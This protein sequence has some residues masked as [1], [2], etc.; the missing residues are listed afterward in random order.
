MKPYVEILGKGDELPILISCPHAGTTIP[1]DIAV[2][3]HPQFH[4]TQPDS[5]WLIHRLYEFASE[6]GCHIIYGVYSRYVIDLNRNPEGTPHYSDGRRETKLCPTTTFLGD[7]IYID[8]EPDKAEIARRLELYYKPY[9]D[10]VRKIL[11]QKRRQNKHILLFEAHSIAR[12]VPLIRK[13]PFPDVMLG[14]NEGKSAHQDIV[15]LA[16]TALEKAGLNVTLNNPFKGGYLTCSFGNPPEGIHAM[17]LEMA[18]DLYL[19]KTLQLDKEKA[20][21]I[22]EALKTTLISIGKKLRELN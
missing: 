14:D 5:D 21:R 15:L 6:L 2:D 20:G 22:Q 8:K 9:H 18:Q 4:L 7:P 12:S 16:K 19:K 17:Q 3:I 1:K 10:Q 13:E 11:G